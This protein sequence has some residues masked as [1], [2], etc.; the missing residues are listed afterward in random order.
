M[1]R[2]LHDPGLANVSGGSAGHPGGPSAG[3]DRLADLCGF[4][5][6]LHLAAPAPACGR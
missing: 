3:H 1:D 2:G 5:R 6:W 4:L